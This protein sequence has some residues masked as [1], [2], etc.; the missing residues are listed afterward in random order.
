MGDLM[1]G[2][3]AARHTGVLCCFCVVAFAHEFSCCAPAAA[4][5][6]V[7]WWRCDGTP[8]ALLTCLLTCNAMLPCY[9]FALCSPA[10]LL[11]YAPLLCSWAIFRCND[12]MLCSDAMLGCYAQI[13]CSAA[14]SLDYA[15]VAQQCCI[16]AAQPQHSL[17]HAVREWLAGLLFVPGLCGRDGAT[18]RQ[19]WLKAPQAFA[20]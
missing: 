3:S 17:M 15:T 7:A 2:S 19:P 11:H 16:N 9:T 18:C 5:L 20:S 14:A 12:P 13:L 4:E 10:M 1:S 6:W 8:V